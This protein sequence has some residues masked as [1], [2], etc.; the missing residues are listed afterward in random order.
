MNNTT[1]LSTVQVTSSASRE[2]LPLNTQMDKIQ[3]LTLYANDKNKD[4]F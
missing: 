4:K 1:R 2:L 3:H